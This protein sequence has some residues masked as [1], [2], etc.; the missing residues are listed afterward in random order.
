V[1]ALAHLVA[2]DMH[3]LNNL[4]VLRYLEG[5]LGLGAE[6]RQAWIHRW[7]REGF[8]ALEALLTPEAGS[9]RFCHGRAPTLADICLVPQV[10]NA[11]RFAFDLGPYPRIRAI[12]AACR[13]LPAFAAADPARQPDAE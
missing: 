5:E 7:L 10:F 2:S 3:P 12:V 9:G 13:A 4:R 11:E 1:Q 6:P 8:D